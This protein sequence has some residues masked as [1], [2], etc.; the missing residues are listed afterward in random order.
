MHGSAF[1]SLWR[2]LLAW[3]FRHR[4]WPISMGLVFAI[5]ALIPASNWMMPISVLMAERFLYLP[6]IGLALTA[7]S[8]LQ[9]F[10]FAIAVDWLGIHD[11]GLASMH[12]S[13][14]HLVK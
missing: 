4:N 10:H 13:Q 7:R 2:C 6:M 12:R 9:L 8:Y 14:L 5:T 1:R 11:H 3:W